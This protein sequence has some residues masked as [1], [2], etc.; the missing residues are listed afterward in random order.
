MWLY[1][2]L[3]SILYNGIIIHDKLLKP[4][5]MKFESFTKEQL[6]GLPPICLHTNPK[7]YTPNPKN[8]FVYWH[9]VCK[10]VVAQGKS[11]EIAK[12]IVDTMADI[13]KRY[14]AGMMYRRTTTKDKYWLER[15][16]LFNVEFGIVLRKHELSMDTGRY[17]DRLLMYYLRPFYDKFV[18][19]HAGN[20][21]PNQD[22]DI[23]HEEVMFLTN[24]LYNI[25]EDILRSKYAMTGWSEWTQG[26]FFNWAHNRVKDGNIPA[27]LKT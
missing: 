16:Y 15:M 1:N 17:R 4:N 23:S 10:N 25:P 26:S 3:T 27:F 18:K 22:P 21:N 13:V 6:L 5:L 19:R 7:P 12:S 9:D 8:M 14:D 11:P 2:I 24:E 20:L